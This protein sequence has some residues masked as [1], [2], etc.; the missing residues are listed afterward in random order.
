MIAR[1]FAFLDRNLWVCWLGL[2][3][4]I[5][6]VCLLDDPLWSRRAP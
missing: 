5:L 3:L 4:C 2:A 6:A 1:L